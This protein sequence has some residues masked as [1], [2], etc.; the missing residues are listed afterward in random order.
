MKNFQETAQART[1]KVV[2]VF[3]MNPKKFGL[4]FSDFSTILYGIYKVHQITYTI[5]VTAFH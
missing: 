2:L 1:T 4:H 3:T 5:E